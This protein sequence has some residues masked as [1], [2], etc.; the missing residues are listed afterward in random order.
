M[1]MHGTMNVKIVATIDLW[2]YQAYSIVQGGREVT[3]HPDN[4][5]LRLNLNLHSRARSTM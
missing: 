2:K 3:V 5:H 1:M 4:M